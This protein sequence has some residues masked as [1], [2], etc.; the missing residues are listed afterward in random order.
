MFWK[1][2]SAWAAAAGAAT[3][4]PFGLIDLAAAVISATVPLAVDTA[5]LT[6][7]AWAAELVYSESYTL[8]LGML[9]SSCRMKMLPSAAAAPAMLTRVY[10]CEQVSPDCR[11]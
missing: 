2:W 10:H 6:A 4:I 7:R 11:G 3:Y 9:D 8:R 1:N 5:E